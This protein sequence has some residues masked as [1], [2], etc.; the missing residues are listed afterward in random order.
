MDITKPQFDLRNYIGGKLDNNIKYIII[1]DITLDKT[2][3]TV[4]IRAGSYNE[5]KGYDGLA[6]FLEHML[7]MGS[8][9]YPKENSFMDIIA[10]YSGF[11]NAYTE[12]TETC[13]YLGFSN[14]GFEQIIDIFSR[15]FIDPLFLKD[16]MDREM[17]AVNNEHLK[18]IN[19]DNWIYNQFIRSISNK[20]IFATGNYETLNKKDIREKMIDFYKKY[21]ISQNI[22]ICV[23]S[24][25]DP[26]KII[27]E[28]NSTFGLIHKKQ[29]KQVNTGIV[30]N[31]KATSYYLKSI[32]DINRLVFIW[33]IPEQIESE[34]YKS[35][36]FKILS[37]LLQINSENSLKFYLKNNGLIN[38]IY[39]YVAN[40]GYFEIYFDLT[41]YG[42]NSMDKIEILLN[43]YL[44]LIY[45]LDFN[46]VVTYFNKL[47]LF[48]FNF[49]N[50]IDTLDL[51]LHLA[52]NMDYYDIKEAYIGSTVSKLFDNSHYTDM[53]KK[54][55]RPSN[56]IK[57]IINQDYNINKNKLISI[58]H[59]NSFY[60][61]IKLDDFKFDSKYFDKLKFIDFTN[62]YMEM[63][64]NVIK[65]L[66]K[67]EIPKYKEK[68]WY[69]GISKFN[70]PIIYF[71][72]NISNNSYYNSPT[73]YL[74]TIISCTI[75][76]YLLSLKFYKAFSV[77]Y[78]ASFHP[79]TSLSSIIISGSGLND[80]IKFNHFIEELFDFIKNIIF[81]IKILSEY[82]IE[83]VINII[84]KS[85]MN[86]MYSNPAEY[87]NYIILLLTNPNEYSNEILLE[88]IKDINSTMI[89]NYLGQLFTMKSN[90][91]TIFYGS[92]Y[93]FSNKKILNFFN[94][95]VKVELP[96]IKPFW[97]CKDKICPINKRT[98]VIE[99]P[100]K[101][102]KSCS[103][104]FYYN[105]GTFL[106]KENLLLYIVVDI[107][108]NKF[109]DELRTKQQ[110][111]YLVSMDTS[112]I[113]TNYGIIQ[114]IQ[115]DKMIDEIIKSIETF[116]KNILSFIK[117][118]KMSEYKERIKNNLSTKDNNTYDCYRRY[119][120][121]IINRTFLFNRKKLLINCIKSVT[122]NDLTDF[123]KRI[124]NKN[125]CIKIIIKGH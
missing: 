36:E 71:T 60:S 10:K 49:L 45:R 77:G 46:K 48:N 2:Y 75:L 47:N 90:L 109:F 6:H 112:N 82:Y 106:P 111:G 57:I 33:E 95:Q 117:E 93:K 115:S 50:K 30:F 91:M 79:S 12:P 78:Y 43:S 87:N 16:T 1:N 61:H 65:N 107:L 105:V 66:D 42:F 25:I 26:S 114:H 4:N 22:S 85:I 102:Q 63:K 119:S 121:E 20:N 34:Q 96:K 40:E 41:P 5:T 11:H 116:N 88:K 56:Q 53:Y 27:K 17:M 92:L 9:K 62:E 122:F 18:N 23:A 58:D 64:P 59:Y 124:I 13:Y 52:S 99:H 110:L 113:M 84:N 21:Y 44:E 76:N 123:I 125:N 15:F 24:N 104:M 68:Y 39:S 38:N 103:I 35:G 67:Y 14:E 19:D 70:E 101:N 28:L 89:R 73:N 69:G 98:L 55:I 83:S 54:Y 108:S 37:Q 80:E 51:C 31:S 32:R 8:E 81:N 29:D 100:D 3:I 72:F 86:E 74:L 94:N 97:L 120:S 7:F 118:S